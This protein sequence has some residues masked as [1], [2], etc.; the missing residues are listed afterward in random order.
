MKKA[1]RWWKIS[2]TAKGFRYRIY[3]RDDRIDRQLQSHLN[4]PNDVGSDQCY[5]FVIRITPSRPES[6]MSQDFFLFPG[7]FPL[8]GHGSIL[9]TYVKRICSV[10]LDMRWI[11]V[12]PRSFL[13]FA[14]KNLSS[15]DEQ[16][17]IARATTMLANLLYMFL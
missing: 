3:H 5:H 11:I 13:T 2:S 12:I 6:P 9:N 4:F 16:R 15:H 10:L 8:V 7:L 17:P 14:I 1:L